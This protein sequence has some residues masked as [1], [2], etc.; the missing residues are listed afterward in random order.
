MKYAIK[1]SN[2]KWRIVDAETQRLAY[3]DGKLV[4]DGGYGMRVQAERRITKLTG[5]EPASGYLIQRN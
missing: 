2:S 3:L 1:R 4:D 5:V